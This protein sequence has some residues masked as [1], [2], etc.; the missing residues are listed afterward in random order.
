MGLLAAALLA[1]AA[2]PAS[3]RAA[4]CVHDALLRGTESAGTAHFVYLVEAGALAA[5]DAADRAEARAL[6]HDQRHDDGRPRP[7]DGPSCSGRSGLPSPPPTVIEPASPSWAW[8]AAAEPTAP[9]DARP[10]PRSQ[11]ALL[12]VHVGPSVFHPPRPPLA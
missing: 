6:A 3:A 7:G 12:P 5:P 9:P 4:G 8:V 10:L 1:L 11:A 2:M